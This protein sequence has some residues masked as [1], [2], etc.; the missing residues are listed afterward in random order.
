MTSLNAEEATLAGEPCASAAVVDRVALCALLCLLQIPSVEGTD[1]EEVSG[2]QVDGSIEFYFVA[3]MAGLCL[4][5][6]W[7]WLKKL[8]DCLDAWW[9]G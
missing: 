2:L 5:V 1:Q 7:E 9:A 4:L 8:W 6:V 3:G